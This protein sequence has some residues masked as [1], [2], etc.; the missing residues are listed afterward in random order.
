MGSEN[1]PPEQQSSAEV[2]NEDSKTPALSDFQ[3][4]T[5]SP[6]SV[7]TSQ[8]KTSQPSADEEPASPQTEA[9]NSN[10]CHDKGCTYTTLDLTA[11]TKEDS[12]NDFPPTVTDV[13]APDQ[14]DPCHLRQ[15]LENS[16]PTGGRQDESDE[17]AKTECVITKENLSIPAPA[18]V[19]GAAVEEQE[20]AEPNQHTEP[21]DDT[22]VCVIQEV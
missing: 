8:Q 16:D 3:E 15:T 21:L 14:S 4:E 18:A 1:I 17:T 20:D 13:N 6:S 19:C 7:K 11:L 10:E 9:L 22:D 5:A 12:L 2:P